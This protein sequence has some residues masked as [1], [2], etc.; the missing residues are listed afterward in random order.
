MA[1]HSTLQEV[2]EGAL[3]SKGSTLTIASGVISATDSY[4]LVGT[5]AA[6][7]T[8]NL[9]TINGAATAGQILVLQA[10]DDGDDVVLVKRAGGVGNINMAANVTL[11]EVQD[12]V[13]LIWNGTYWNLLA[14]ATAATPS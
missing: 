9:T 10:S 6:A 14:S 5:E 8:D 2:K 4:H 11:A 3:L 12:T 1:R 13:T 7:S